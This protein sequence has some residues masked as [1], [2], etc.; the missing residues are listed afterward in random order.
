[1][2]KVDWRSNIYFKEVKTGFF[3]S[4]KNRIVMDFKNDII[5]ECHVKCEFRGE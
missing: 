5:S 1:M 4:V 3:F 2:S